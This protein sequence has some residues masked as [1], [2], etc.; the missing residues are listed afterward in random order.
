[1]VSVRERMGQ[2]GIQKALG[3][4]NYVILLL[5]LSEA[6]FLCIAGGIFGLILVQ[7]GAMIASH[8]AEFSINLTLA[9]ILLGIGVSAIIGAISGFIPAYQAS[10]MDPV[11]AIYKL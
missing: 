3:A 1:F 8:I 11:K 10:S 5:F 7:I 9:N 4:K 6:I 2:I